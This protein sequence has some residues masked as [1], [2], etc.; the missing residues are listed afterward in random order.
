M[1]LMSWLTLA[2]CLQMVE[3]LQHTALAYRHRHR[4]WMLMVV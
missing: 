2:P 3:H 4:T 1:I